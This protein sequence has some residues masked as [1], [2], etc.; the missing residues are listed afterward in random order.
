MDTQSLI[1]ALCAT[2][3]TVE[4]GGTLPEI[5]IPIFRAPGQFVIVNGEE[6]QVYEF[7]D[8]ASAQA[9]RED[10]SAQG[11]DTIIGSPE[12]GWETPPHFFGAGRV[13][14]LYSGDERDVLSALESVLGP[15]VAG[16]PMPRLPG[17]PIRISWDEARRFILSGQVEF[18]LQT[19]S[20]EVQLTLHN[21]LRFVTTEPSI[22]EVFSVVEQCGDPCA[23]IGLATE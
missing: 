17:A 7:A 19:H 10:T 15:Q 1:Q 14:V 5:A 13:I 20:L 9:V 3:A 8:E 21:R 4:D 22:D 2:G 18:I 6:M 16:R 12:V 11:T 23:D